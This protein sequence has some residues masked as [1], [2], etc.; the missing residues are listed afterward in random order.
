[1]EGRTVGGVEERGVLVVDA[2][3]D[4]EHREDVEDD[5]AEERRADRARDG[6]VLAR[7]L[8]RGEGDELDAAVGVEGVDEGLGEG[9]EAADEGLGVVPV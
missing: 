4:G 1:M 5:D 9:G 8:A 2:E 7:A 3:P 6:L